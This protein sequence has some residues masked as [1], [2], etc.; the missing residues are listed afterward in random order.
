MLRALDSDNHGP[1]LFFGGGKISLN[2]RDGTHDA[3]CTIPNNVTGRHYYL[4]TIA[5]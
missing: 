2:T 3:F 1:D 4:T 5:P